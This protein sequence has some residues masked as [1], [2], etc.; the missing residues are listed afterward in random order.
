MHAAATRA[1]A[2]ASGEWWRDHPTGGNSRVSTLLEGRPKRSQQCTNQYSTGAWQPGGQPD[3]VACRRKH[4]QRKGG[5]KCIRPDTK[6]KACSKGPCS[7][8]A[9]VPCAWQ[10]HAGPVAL[11]MCVALQFHGQACNSLAARL[12]RRTSAQ[13]GSVNGEQTRGPRQAPASD[14]RF[15]PAQHRH[16]V[17]SKA[18]PACLSRRAGEP[19]KES[20]LGLSTGRRV[21]L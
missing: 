9:R 4:G 3:A 21:A 20:R 6:R 8:L 15:P 16:I 5:H 18:K 1:A 2:S 14:R 13:R 7:P 17:L 11:V 19:A 12:A 10:V